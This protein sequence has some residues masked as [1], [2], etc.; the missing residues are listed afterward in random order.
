MATQKWAPGI[1]NYLSFRKTIYKNS[2]FPEEMQKYRISRGLEVPLNGVVAK[3]KQTVGN[4]GWHS[5]G[6]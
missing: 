6:Q 4:R 3:G 1:L 5:D 2:A